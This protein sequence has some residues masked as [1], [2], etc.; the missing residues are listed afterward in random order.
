MTYEP[1][2]GISVPIQGAR[3]RPANRSG[4]G[5]G[6]DMKLLSKKKPAGTGRAPAKP[7]F[8]L[9]ELVRESAMLASL[10]PRLMRV[11]L[12]GSMEGDFR[13]RLWVATSAVN[14]CRY[15]SYMH[16]NWA[17]LEGVSDEEI[18][19]LEHLDLDRL[20]RRMHMAAEFAEDWVRKNFGSVEPDIDRRFRDTFLTC[21]REDIRAVI[22]LANFANRASNTFDAFLGRLGGKPIAGSRF[23][24]EVAISALVGG[25]V[26]GVTPALM[27]MRRKGPVGLF[28][29]FRAFSRRFSPPS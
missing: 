14:R 4:V 16:Q 1:V 8:R 26:V 24:D 23:V 11:Y 17:R 13:E 12:N 5:K 15:C 6:N 3:T 18:R 22:R 2:G 20:D 27:A 7:V 9:P 28:R 10:S 29:E 19:N 21:E 25:A